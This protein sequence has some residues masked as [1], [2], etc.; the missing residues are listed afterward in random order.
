MKPILTIIPCLALAFTACEGDDD[1]IITEK[2][3][4][5]T[6][7]YFASTDGQKADTYYKP[8]AGH[9]GDPMPFY[10][11]VAKDFKVLYLQDYR[12]NPAATYH[13]IWGVSTSDAASYVSLGELIP[14][15]SADEQDAAIGT[16]CTVY[17]SADGKYYTFYTGNKYLP[18]SE[19]SGQ[20]IMLATSEDFKTWKKDRSLY[21]KGEDYGYSKNDFRDPFVF[22]GDDGLW[23]MIVAT[24]KSGKGWL[25]EF[26]SSNLTDWTFVGDFMM[27]V[28][29]RFYECPDIFK[30]GDW[31]YMVYSEKHSAIRKVQYFKGRT[32]EELKAS[33]ANDSP[34]W[35][36]DHE[37]YLDSRGFY[38]GKTASDGTNRYIWGWCPTRAGEDNTAVGA[39]PAEPEWAG[40]LVAHK[41][42]QN[43]DGSLTLGPVDAID[44]KY[45]V[46]AEAKAMEQSASGVSVSGGSYAMS[47][48]SYV[49]FS[50]LGYENKISF[51]VTT[52]GD[53]DKFGLSLVRGS[54]SNVYY[55]IVVNPES[56][57]RRK[58][59]F[60]Q[61]GPSGIGFIEGIDGNL[62]SAPADRTY[63]ITVYTD[64]S[65]C[66]VYVN[67]A[68]AYTNR[69]YG[70]AK[71]PWSINCYDGSITV[72]NV[73][74][75]QQ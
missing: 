6:T 46:P 42:I 44:A 52:S 60:E 29:D 39:S 62:F 66:V 31:W 24:T 14:C 8:Y 49:L 26:T 45:S 54:D 55:S 2:D 16:G 35:P 65:V 57:D 21:I 22:A 69:I 50:R 56:A 74:V 43:S 20:V 53:T 12:P 37:G 25:I 73:S 70:I 5:G 75:M 58:I 68:Q 64:N 7:T 4:Q 27:M 13:P 1:P 18:T 72:S 32:L 48:G 34:V 17:N 33:T 28:W 30:M 11:P 38:A 47:G 10:D 19:E 3:W 9:V 63:D 59:N 15:G 23:H 40:S 71:N 67:G 51:T 36:D 41:V 61:E